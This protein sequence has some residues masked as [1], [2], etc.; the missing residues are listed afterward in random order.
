MALPCA[1]VLF[2]IYHTSISIVSNYEW[3]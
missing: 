3:L 2:L 1:A